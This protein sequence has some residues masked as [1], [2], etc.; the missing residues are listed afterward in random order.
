MIKCKDCG[1][2]TRDLLGVGTQR[3]CVAECDLKPA[4][5]KK[6]DEC[7]TKWFTEYGEPGIILPEKSSYVSN[8]NMASFN[9]RATDLAVRVMKGLEYPHVLRNMLSTYVNSVEG[10][11][12]TKMTIVLKRGCSLANL[13][14]GIVKLATSIRVDDGIGIYKILK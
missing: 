14:P 4:A 2:P 12:T 5:T 13:P 3:Y 6:T 9:D 11:S 7:K 1:G 8:I 10:C